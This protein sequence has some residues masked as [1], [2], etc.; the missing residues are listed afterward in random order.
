MIT[1]YELFEDFFNKCKECSL[2]EIIKEYGGGH[3][4]I[5]SYKSTHRD[6]DIYNSYKNGK[7]IR[8]LKREFGLSE[9]RI[10]AIIRELETKEPKA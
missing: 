3:I 2:E 5:P 6:I 7:S 8:A 10:R 4:Y 9:S 1:T